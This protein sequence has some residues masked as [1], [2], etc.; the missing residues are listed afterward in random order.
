MWPCIPAFVVDLVAAKPNT[1]AAFDPP[2]A[3]FQSMVSISVEAAVN[4]SAE[5]PQLMPEPGKEQE[6]TKES[7]WRRVGEPHGCNC[8]R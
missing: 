1:E 5:L 7:L 6:I 3:D 8:L 2:L 4:A